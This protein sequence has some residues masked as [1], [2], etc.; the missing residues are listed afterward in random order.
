MDS[1]ERFCPYCGGTVEPGD[2]PACASCGRMVYSQRHTLRNITDRREEP[3]LSKIVDYLDDNN[4][5]KAMSIANELVSECDSNADYL[6]LRG[7]VFAHYGE[8]GKALADWKAGLENLQTLTD[9]DAYVCVITESVTKMLC[10]QEEHFIEIDRLKL[11]DRVCSGFFKMLGVSVKGLIYWDI[12]YALREEMARRESEGKDTYDDIVR[13]V[14]ERAL[15]YCRDYR[16]LP[17]F[18]DCYLCSIGFC[19]D[20]YDD[21]DMYTEHMFYSIARVIEMY[22]STMTGQQLVDIMNEWDDEHMTMLED[23]F[24]GLKSF[25]KSD[26]MVHKILKHV[27]AEEVAETD[28]ELEGDV[29][30]YVRRCLRLDPVATEGAQAN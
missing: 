11:I 16:L 20:T 26:G 17:A 27:N 2:K 22:T 29:D 15:V 12:C 4:Q 19:E 5:E 30:I 13:E 3:R 10:Y 25:G 28:A 21:D 9:V 24:K 6:F 1:V 7:A 23:L 14:F 18:I 8:D